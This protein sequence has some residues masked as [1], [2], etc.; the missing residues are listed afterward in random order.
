MSR[1]FPVR[2]A[3]ALLLSSVFFLSGCSVRPAE[4]LPDSPAQPVT[5]SFFAMDTVM[6]LT[7]YGDETQLDAAQT[8]VETLEA[9]LSVTREDSEIYAINHNG[10]GVLSA[11]TA[12][13]LY[14][15]LALCSRTE[16]QNNTKRVILIYRCRR[17][18]SSSNFTKNTVFHDSSIPQTCGLIPSLLCLYIFFLSIK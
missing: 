2:R 3:L 10:G 17:D 7:L 13:L 5:S 4:S 6:E 15:S 14:Q 18:F 9:A 12:D 1:S 8:C 16:I 11:Q